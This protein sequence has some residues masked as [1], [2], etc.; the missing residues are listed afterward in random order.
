MRQ[1]CYLSRVL[2]RSSA[3]QQMMKTASISVSS[4][5]KSP[6]CRKTTLR[7]L[8]TFSTSLF[9]SSQSSFFSSVSCSSTSLPKVAQQVPNSD[10]S[11][12]SE[13]TSSK[14]SRSRFFLPAML[15]ATAA[16]AYYREEVIVSNTYSTIK[17]DVV[18]C[19]WSVAYWNCRSLFLT[20]SLCISRS[21]SPCCDVATV[22]NVYFTKCRTQSSTFNVQLVVFIC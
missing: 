9:K 6:H 16:A 19:M 22:T 18:Y 7:S 17:V 5:L 12:S 2:S 4:L 11:S 15:L 10:K 8:H 3:H 20:P 1:S 21:L 13:Q 14:K